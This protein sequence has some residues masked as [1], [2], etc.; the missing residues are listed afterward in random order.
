M[1]VLLWALQPVAIMLLDDSCADRGSLAQQVAALAFAVSA[2]GHG[3]RPGR[4][5]RLGPRRARRPGVAWRGRVRGPVLR[6]A[7]VLGCSLTGA[8]GQE[9]PASA[10]GS[11]LPLIP[12]FGL[13]AGYLVGE[14]LEPRQWVGAVVIVAAA[15][16]TI[17]V[18]E[19]TTAVEP[20]ART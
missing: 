7:G 13:A 15:T 4:R 6:A 14:R 11:F 9:V 16:T 19:R 8:C 10:A 2:G 1:S 18:R 12:V 20:V 17:A 3:R 5:S